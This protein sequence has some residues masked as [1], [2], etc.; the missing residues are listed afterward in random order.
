MSK[1]QG[2]QRHDGRPFLDR[3]LPQ[4]LIAPSILII[5]G[6]LILPIL[7]SIYLSFHEINF[8][9]NTYQFVGLKNYIEM[10]QDT[11]YLKSISLTVYFTVIT[12][13][14]EIFMG[15][16][17]ALVLNQKFKGRGFV[18]GIMILP[19][20]LPTVVNAVMWKW[21]FNA[22]YGVF[23]ALL[24]KLGLIDSYQ[25]WLGTP[26]SAL[27]CM[28]FAN[29]WKETPYVV[30]LTIAAL[31]NIS[32]DIY[33]AARV[34]GSNVFHTFRTI[35]LPLIK[36]VVLILAITK[37][38]WALQTFDL[39]FILTGGGPASGTELMTFFIHKNTFKFLKF[40]YGSAM[41]YMLSMVC[42]VLT[43]IYIKVFA[44][45]ED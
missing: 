41:S 40:G 4:L 43:F 15:V 38:I 45:K 32:P 11:Y 21:I 3:H 33:E 17:I 42:F 14:T 9:S 24:L 30:L 1:N 37:T 25:V 26:L 18:R 12:V 13:F 34:D 23:N 6:V 35:T 31:A 7:Y 16:G 2:G 36:P 22:N 27:N 10:F 20:A 29:I 39:V 19:W 44:S 28:L 8:S 5:L